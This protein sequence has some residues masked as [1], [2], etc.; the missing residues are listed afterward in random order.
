MVHHC[1]G[2]D[3]PLLLSARELIRP[4]MTAVGQAYAVKRICGY[5]TSFGARNARVNKRKFDI[6]KCCCPRQ[7][8]RQLEYEADVLA[9]DGRACVLAQL[10]SVPALEG[11]SARIRPLQKTQ[12]VHQGRL[13]R[14]RAAADCNVLAVLDRERHV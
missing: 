3:G 1:T 4:M 13:P 5:A 14:T 10:C 2:N 8:G 12:K 9:S 11:I 7:K 6:F